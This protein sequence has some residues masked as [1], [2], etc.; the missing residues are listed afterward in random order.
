MLSRVT[1]A[2]PVPA[3]AQQM[4]AP[5]AF[6]QLGQARAPLPPPRILNKSFNNV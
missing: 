1:H 6:T 4:I 3:Q 2:L 5:F